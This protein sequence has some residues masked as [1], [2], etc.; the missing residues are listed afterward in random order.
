MTRS[1]FVMVM[2]AAVLS[3]AAR[4]ADPSGEMSVVLE[5]AVWRDAG[6][7][8]RK[9]LTLKMREDGGRWQ[10]LVIGHARSYNWGDHYGCL[11]GATREGEALR[12]SVKM[13]IEADPWT[14]T[15]GCGEYAILLRPEA[16]APGR[17][18]GTWTG[19]FK[20]ERGEGAAR[21]ARYGPLDGFAAPAAGEH[22]R[23][24]LRRAAI[25][26]LRK[27]AETDW[28]RAMLER[29][30][31]DDESKSSAAVGRGLLYVLTGDAAFAA[32][33]RRLLL[34]DV[35]GA[36]WNWTT[37]PYHD[38]AVKAVEGAIAY[39]LVYET[40]D[41]AFRRRMAAL[42][43]D[44]LA[45]YYRGADQP[46][47]NPND[48]SNWSAMYRSGLGM[49][50][51]SL[52]GE[53]CPYPG[54]P[55]G[56][57]I[58]RLAE[59]EGLAIGKGVPV[60][61]LRA[62]QSWTQWLVAAPVRVEPHVDGLAS[63]GGAAAARPEEGTRIMVPRGE[64]GAA[65]DPAEVVFAPLPAAA[66]LSKDRAAKIGKPD[67]EGAVDVTAALGGEGPATAYLY[68]ILQN[69]APGC[70]RVEMLAKKM[71]GPA[72]F[73]AGRRLVEGDIVYL[74]KGRLPVLA[75]LP[76]ASKTGGFTNV[77]FYLRL[78]AVGD[79]EAA[80][81]LAK[82]KARYPVDLA[83]WEEGRRRHEADGAANPVVERWLGVGRQRIE[84]WADRAL[85]D[86]GWNHEG[87]AYTQHSYRLVLPF[88]H[89]Y[90]NVTG[91]EL[92]SS[93]KLNRCLLNYVGRTILGA[94]SAR[95]Q[96]FAPGGGPLGVDNWA[97]GFGLL[98]SE[99]RPYA[100]WTWN[101]TQALADAGKLKLPEVPVD[102]LDPMSAAF[103]FVSYPTDVQEK[104][105]GAVRDRISADRDRGGYVLRNRWQD[106]DD[107][108]TTIYLDANFRGGGWNSL[109]AGDLRL[110]G[111]GADWS[112]RGMGWGNGS[113][114]KS[115]P[116]L[117]QDQTVL[118]APEVVRGGR[119]G[120]MTFFAAQSDG[121]AILS[122]DMTDLYTPRAA[123]AG[124]GDSPEGAGPSGP[125]I[126]GLR[127]LAIDYSGASGAPALAAVVDRVSG[128]AGKNVWQFV[129][130]RAHTVE[131]AAEGSPPGLPAGGQAGFT[132]RAASGATLT[133]AIV[134]PALPAV[135][136]V[137]RT[138]RHEINYHGGHKRADFARTVIRVTGGEFFFVVMTLQKG[139]AP[140]VTVQGAG[141]DARAKVGR[142]T[143]RFDGEK[144]VLEKAAAGG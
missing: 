5:G 52:L 82:R 34:E 49:C 127:A 71:L 83:L 50:A 117:R 122:M 65:P 17:L 94:E 55:E 140:A 106:D 18:A 32:E 73:I 38:P 99:Y 86:I 59:P 85:G 126:R 60:V 100:L 11:A 137:A 115:A 27:K 101:R 138:I 131:V 110:S 89:A 104:N 36:R 1:F 128:T 7:D 87:E 105:P 144:I 80:A 69:A 64:G 72:V 141:P 119:E 91:Y 14:P 20:G 81:W 114:S 135:E 77:E 66:V 40:C 70:Y 43:A 67:W 10:A 62:G 139:P 42:F 12:L 109:E 136:A 44:H 48:G 132:I 45:Y 125:P 108:A 39:D 8:A 3:A 102:R 121:S 31:A 51:L 93:G 35:D 23:M 74:G 123:K 130:D 103:R 112:V 25:P 16:G 133:A 143:V 111:L 6:P 46:L 96:A 37:G 120:R 2:A 76:V 26:A 54:R 124:D 134:A 56:P 68:A 58:A 116:N 61:P 4:A 88:A 57:E 30:K 92:A 24:L 28:G 41:G 75:Q 15:E 84:N 78:H 29:L 47:F 53:P 142:Q 63:I 21:A 79:E 129:T 33:A 13:V 113:Y 90:R 118:L 9:P 95:M 107:C 97:R 22:P 98:L 19:T